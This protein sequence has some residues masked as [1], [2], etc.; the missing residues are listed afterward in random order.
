MGLE[1]HLVQQITE[2][3]AQVPVKIRDIAGFGAIPGVKSLQRLVGLL[4]E[5]TPQ[6][7]VGLLA[8]PRA[9]LAQRPHQLVETQDGDVQVVVKLIGYA[10]TIS[11]TG[12]ANPPRQETGSRTTRNCPGS[13]Y[14]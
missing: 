2:F 14:P 4:Q 7:R 13:Q 8:V 10:L 12:H 3:L 1:P 5:I 6:A 9:L 11:V